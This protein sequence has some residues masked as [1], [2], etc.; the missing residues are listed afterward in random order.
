M[1]LT[2]TGPINSDILNLESPLSRIRSEIGSRP[3]QQTSRNM[4]ARFLTPATAASITMTKQK[5]KTT[6]IAKEQQEALQARLQK[7]DM[8]MPP[9][10]FLELIGK[11]A[12]GRVFKA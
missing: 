7:N 5:E 2:S 9:F 1:T 11:G 8:E 3:R 10:E 6:R 4:D 12:F